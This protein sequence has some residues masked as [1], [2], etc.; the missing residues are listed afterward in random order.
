MVRLTGIAA[1]VLAIAFSGARSQCT[2]SSARLPIAQCAGWLA[3]FDATGGEGW[4][5]CSDKRQDPCA[6]SPGRS[7][8]DVGTT[9]NSVR[10]SS[11]GLNGTL[12]ESIGAWVDIKSFA[13]DNNQLSGPLP[14]TVS[15]WTKLRDIHLD[16]NLFAGAP[17]PH[18]PFEQLQGCGLDSCCV[19]IQGGNDNAFQC[20]WPA[21]VT[22][23]CDKA[24]WDSHVRVTD[25]DCV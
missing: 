3:F 20:P 2:G 9:I 15:R 21:G 1:A 4:T 11:T 8:N 18:L 5:Q 19:L 24:T 23:H 22:S 25:A 12:P 6:C 10:L 14:T 13:V 7:C 17:L 16:G